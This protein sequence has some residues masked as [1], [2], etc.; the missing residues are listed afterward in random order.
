MSISEPI[1]LAE[2]DWN[3]QGLPVSR[4]FGDVYFSSEGGLDEARHVFLE[5]NHLPQR[6]SDADVFTV[7]ETGFGSGLNFLAL[8]QLWERVAPAQARLRFFSV[9]KHPLR[10]EDMARIHSL[11]PE[12]EPYG[13]AL[14]AAL[15]LPSP[16]FHRLYLADGRVQLTLM[17]GDALSMLREQDAQADA[18]FLDGF[19]PRLNPELWSA[20]LAEELR[21]LSSGGASVATFSTSSTTQEA[22]AGAGFALEK[23][24]GFGRK[25]HM[26]TGHLA[27][28][29]SPPVLAPPKEVSV[30]GA[31]LAGAATAHALAQRG[32]H[33]Q[34][35]EAAQKAA[36]GASGNPSAIFYPA[37]TVGW[38]PL[39]AFYFAGFSYS[40]GLLRQQQDVPQRSCGMLLFRKPHEAPQRQGKVLASMRPDASL[41]YGVDAA[42]A[43][44]IAGIGLAQ[45][46]L[47][48]PRGGWVDLGEWTQ[49]LL[50]HPHI[51]TRYNAPTTSLKTSATMVLC[52]GWQAQQLVPWLQGSM[53][54]VGGQVSC[55]PT[56]S[57]LVGLRC[58]LSYGGYLT[59]AI[60][61]MHHLGATYEKEVTA[62][63]VT[64]E[65]HKQ[66]LQKLAVFMPQAA[67]MDAP[68]GGWAA[69]RSVTRD[70]LPLVG[71]LQEGVYANLSH[72]SRG[73][74]S[75]ALAGEYIASQLYDDPLPLPRSLAA[76][77]R[78]DRFAKNTA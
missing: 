59:P 53:H 3:E 66:N 10:P 43:S 33:V 4:T 45:G 52:N 73:L 22:L 40:L 49:R 12:I 14:R 5:G 21:R 37:V 44:D 74:L 38:Q 8:W 26:L 57:P 24:P 71:K 56:A 13:A 32:C 29:S 77:L 60:D 31:G 35:V 55:V 23:R 62:M 70:R 69:L 64:A 72:A 39:S 25:K 2:L 61:G 27:Q 50:Q 67:H 16:G 76:L 28:V 54:P 46:G 18:W 47:Y 58:V 78:A 68:A 65:G 9:E 75:C 63:T 19:A 36:S 42:Q 34:V 30:I 1:M 11:F 41:F 17:Y 7:G 51:T 48:F 6:L 15:P 20:E